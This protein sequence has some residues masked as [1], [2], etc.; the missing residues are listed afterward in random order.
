M[1]DLV[2]DTRL[3]KVTGF[4]DGKV[5]RWFGIPYGLPPV[6]ERRFKRSV[7]AQP[8]KGIRECTKMSP[9]PYDFLDGMMKKMMKGTNPYSEDC[10]YLNVWVPANVKPGD[11]RPVFVWI[12]GGANH[13]GEAS[14]PGYDLTAF[15]EKDIV[16]VNFNYRVGPLGFYDF[17][18]LDPS[19]DSNCALSDM[20]LALHW[21]QDNIEAFGGDP[22]QVTI[23]GE[24]AG[25]TAVYTL[26]SCPS[27]HGLFQRAIAMSGLPDN[28]DWPRVQDLNIGLFLDAIGIAKEDISK[29]RELSPEDLQKGSNAL[30]HNNDVYPGILLTGAEVDGD[31]LPY[32]PW[33]AM[34]K[35]ISKDVPCIFGTCR[36]EGTLFYMLKMTPVNWDQV[37]QMLDNSGCADKLTAFKKQYGHLKEKEAMTAIARDRMFWAYSI[38]CSDAQ[39]EYN[40]VYRYRFDFESGMEKLSGLKA[41]HGSDIGAGLDTW[42]SL[43]KTLGMLT[44]KKT[45]QHVHDHLHGAF[46]HF[47]KTGDPNGGSIRGWAPYTKE[48][49]ET[50]LINTECRLVRNPKG[51]DYPLWKDIELYR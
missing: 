5:N 25:G 4:A 31:L 17:S 15:A 43:P 22:K 19:F 18:R 50:M 23:C 32:K 37:A 46:V 45:M 3:G 26:L 9:R 36:E 1:S 2:R 44:S 16:A 34:E 39:S 30:V 41:T 24:S 11:K 35:G 33:E 27:A 51:E 6:G 10:L 13:T 47:V 28:V 12:Y 20:L 40:R 38:R 7:E 48:D 49:R 42:E 29:L 8:W 14:D 21:V